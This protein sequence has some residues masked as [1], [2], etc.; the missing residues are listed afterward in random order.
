LRKGCRRQF[1]LDYANFGCVKAIR[2]LVVPLTINGAGGRD[3]ER[4]LLLSAN[5]ILK[6]LLE[7]ARTA[8]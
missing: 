3:I 7:A 2:G 8:F 5:T 4:V 1:I 6:T